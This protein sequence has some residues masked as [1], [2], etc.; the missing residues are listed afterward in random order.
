MDERSMEGGSTGRSSVETWVRIGVAALAAAHGAVWWRALSWWPQLPPR[1]P[2]HFDA[3]GEPDGWA[4]RSV[5]AWFLA[6]AIM[7]FLCALLGAI[8]LWINGVAR[9]SPDLMNVP[10]RALFIRLSPAARCEAVLPVRG[11]LVWVLVGIN[12]L[13][14]VIVEGM[15]RVATL[16][17]GTVSILPVVAFVAFAGAL[18]FVSIRA[19]ARA[20]ERL[21]RREGL[22]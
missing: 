8:A 17:Q 9:T 18:S 11:V 20:V 12:V 19:T 5:V 4:A 2:I 1:I 7:L 22:L 16:G 6:P 13:G 14:L 21:A 15:G 10:H 3:A